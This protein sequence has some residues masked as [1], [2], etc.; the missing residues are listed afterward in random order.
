M[1]SRGLAAAGLAKEKGSGSVGRALPQSPGC[2]GPLANPGQYA[3]V[4]FTPGSISLFGGGADSV[5]RQSPGLD[6]AFLGSLG[7]AT[8]VELGT[9]QLVGVFS[10]HSQQDALSHACGACFCF[11]A[12]GP[13]PGFSSSSGLVAQ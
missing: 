4:A 13:G 6:S 2:S 11:S 5:T 1:D 9:V 8:S 3:P 10:Q 7:I 12:V